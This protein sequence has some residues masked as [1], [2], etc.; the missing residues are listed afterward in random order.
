MHHLNKLILKNLVDELP[1]LKFE[2]KRVC[3]D[4]QKV[5]QSKINFK[6]KKFISNTR[7]TKPLHMDL[8]GPS[9]NMSIGNNYYGL[10][11]VDNYSR[12]TWTLFIVTK[13]HEFIAFK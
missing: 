13:D 12:F 1:K 8:F 7:P 5:K 2:K 4:C 9:R 3:D 11:I 10:M 6:S